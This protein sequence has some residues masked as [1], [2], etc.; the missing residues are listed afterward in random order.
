MRIAISPDEN[1][2]QPGS[3]AADGTTERSVNLKVASALQAA[4]QRCGQ[5]VWFDPSITFDQ[6]V[7]RANSDG[8]QLLVACAHNESTPG[9][10]GTQFVFCPGGQTFGK[11]SA[12]A[13]AVYAELAK[14]PGWP[15]R[16]SDAVENVEECCGF[17]NDTVYTEYLF[18][19]PDDEPI[20][21]RPTYP[22]DAAEA[23][24]RGLAAVYGFTY[25]SP[26]GTPHPPPPPPGPEPTNPAAHWWGPYVDLGGQNATE[27]VELNS[28]CHA[29]VWEAGGT[30]YR[31]NTPVQPAVLGEYA[32]WVLANKIGGVWY[33]MDETGGPQGSGSQG[34]LAPADAWWVE[35]A[36][37]DSSGCGGTAPPAVALAG[38]GRWYSLTAASALAAE[39]AAELVAEPVPAP[40]QGP[41]VSL[42]RGALSHARLSLQTAQEAIDAALKA[43]GDA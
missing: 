34:R 43:L 31:G 33:V 1:P 26:G 28:P 24:A 15:A 41:D 14:I 25:V 17:N 23:T 20:W 40:T 42:A 4:L 32:Q 2:D 9:L 22:Q 8:T 30:W 5:D 3:V 21:S 6:R 11:Q 39:P 29:P 36:V 35:D 27:V 10:R 13:T 38:K 7:Q 19:S 12:A 37:T 16:I 18:M